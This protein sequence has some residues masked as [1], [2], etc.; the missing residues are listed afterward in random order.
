MYSI[1]LQYVY[2]YM[3]SIHNR[4]IKSDAALY[5]TARHVIL[6]DAYHT[7]GTVNLTIAVLICRGGLSPT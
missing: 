6:L 4:N 3:R 1:Y 7:G 5:Y 2:T